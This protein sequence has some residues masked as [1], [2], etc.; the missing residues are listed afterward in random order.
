M[1]TAWRGD[2]W[3]DPAL[4]GR[5]AGPDVRAA[6]GLAT[7]LAPVAASLRR[8]P[9]PY[10]RAL[11]T[12]GSADLTTARAAEPHLDA[13][14]ILA[15]AG[16]PD[17][18]VVGVDGHS[19]FGVFAAGGPGGGLRAEDGPDGCPRVSGTKPWSS[20]GATLTHALVTVGAPERPE[21]HAVPLRHPG[22]TVEP[23][24]WVPRGLTAIHTPTLLFDAVP[25]V[26][27]AP[28][29]WYLTRPGFSWGGIG[30]AAVWF[31]AATALAGA[32]V[33]A[34]GRRDP[35]QVALL[36]LGRV[37]LALHGCLLALRDAA[38]RIEE[39]DVDGAPLLAARVR[40][41]VA[42]AAEQ[43]L[44]T[45]GHALGPA[46]LTHDEDHARRVADLTVYVRQHHAERDV[47]RLGS[48]VLTSPAPTAGR[49][50]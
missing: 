33:G 28:E 22:V 7:E 39:G 29:G 13:V 8:R 2:E 50:S 43:V 1:T 3:G 19:T 32:L 34:A 21:L 16:C 42:A 20:L 26:R 37:D 41:H 24:T 46:P 25:S 40:A 30:V 48:L 49:G 23:T 35:D 45:V 10:L 6:L 9:W 4:R 27:V 5:V 44:A 38:A 36:H 15:Q 31:G 11:A 47:A 18:A 17:L 12:L 14:A